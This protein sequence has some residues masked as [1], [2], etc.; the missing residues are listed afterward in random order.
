MIV[1]LLRLLNMKI[2]KKKFLNCHSCSSLRIEKTLMTPS[3][4][5]K[6]EFLNEKTQRKKLLQLKKLNEYQNLLEKF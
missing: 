1:G 4:V 6:N 3:V 5:N 2:K